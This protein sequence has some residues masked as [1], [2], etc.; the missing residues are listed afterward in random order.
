MTADTIVSRRGHVTCSVFETRFGGG[1]GRVRMC[2]GVLGGHTTCREV[3]GAS[4]GAYDVKKGVGV[5]TREQER[6]GLVVG[7]S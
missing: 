1:T 3:G 4:V 6:A 5:G 7:S 2:D